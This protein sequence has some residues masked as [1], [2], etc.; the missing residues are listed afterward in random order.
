[1]LQICSAWGCGGHS[2]AQPP[3]LSP[4]DPHQPE[5]PAS[6]QWAH[7]L[8]KGSGNEQN[9]GISAERRDLWASWPA[10]F[11]HQRER[12]NPAAQES[13]GGERKEGKEPPEGSLEVRQAA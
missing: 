5:L 10:N 7:R 3:W 8:Q 12:K 4:G 11:G 13:V 6:A 9:A 1:M 2:T